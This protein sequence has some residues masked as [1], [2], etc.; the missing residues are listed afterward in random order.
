LGFDYQAKDN[1]L[2]VS[3]IPANLPVNME[4]RLLEQLIEQAKYTEAV[5]LGKA[6]KI[7]LL[8]SKRTAMK[9]TTP[10]TETEMSALIDQ[11]FACANPNYTPEGRKI[12]RI[13]SLE[14][15]GELLSR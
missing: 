15:V 6:E 8:M 3:G 1:Q 12:L 4:A 13:L 9:P 2:I 5:N 11:L 10:L 14:E 7:A